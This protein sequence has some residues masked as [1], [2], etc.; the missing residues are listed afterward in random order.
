MTSPSGF[1][2]LGLGSN[3]GGRARS[4]GL[5]LQALDEGRVRV[6]RVSSVF[7]SDPVGPVLDQP[8]F[9]NLVAEV[10]TDLD[11]LAL[12][13]RCL[14]VEGRLGRP[15]PRPHTQGPRTIDIDLLVFGPSILSTE[16]L[17]LPHPEMTRRAFVLWP[18]LELCPDL[19][20]P[21]DGLPLARHRPALVDQAIRR[22]GTLQHLL[23]P[24]P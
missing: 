22:L 5:A 2:Y 8:R 17:R 13:R 10:Q 16:A 19:R 9:L 6:C 7:E 18:L 3:L 11:P 24:N 12:L 1:A 15:S 4:L 14:D 21:R 23:H 20:D